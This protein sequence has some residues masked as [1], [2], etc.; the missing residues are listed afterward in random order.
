MNDFKAV[1][2][3]LEEWA[4]AERKQIP[5]LGYSSDMSYEAGINDNTIVAR[6][7]SY[8]PNQRIKATDKA[9]QGITNKLHKK[10]IRFKYVEPLKMDELEILLKLKKTKI[11]KEIRVIHAYI[12]GSLHYELD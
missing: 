2:I 9:I 5:G 10:I 1:E 11:C 7:P 12:A 3:R 4:E 8:S 6:I